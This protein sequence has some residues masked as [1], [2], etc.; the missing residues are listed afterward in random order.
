[1]V[2]SPIDTLTMSF[3]LTS[4]STSILFKLATFKISVPAIWAVPTTRS[5]SSAASK[6]IVQIVDFSNFKKEG[7]Y[8]V[9]LDNGA[10]SYLFDIKP[11]V[12]LKIT[13]AAIK[14][15]YFNRASTALVSTNNTINI[16]CAQSTSK[17]EILVK[18]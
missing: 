7:R 4:T 1:M 16:P 12:N 11:Q 2:E 10:S 6:E 9:A 13:K 8:L 3:S 15:F 14:A 5:P 17:N 18:V